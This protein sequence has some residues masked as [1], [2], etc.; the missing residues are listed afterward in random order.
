MLR[1]LLPLALVFTLLSPIAVKAEDELYL[2]GDSIGIEVRYDGV[3]VSGTYSIQT[4]EGT[5]DPKDNGIEIGDRIVAVNNQKVSS[6]NDLYKALS[7]YQQSK[8]Q[9]SLTVIRNQKTLQLDLNTYYNKSSKNFQSGLYI[10]D[11]ITGVGTLTFYDPVHK[12]FGALGHE[13]MDSDLKQIADV[14]LGTIYPATVNSITKAQEHIAGEKQATI[15]YDKPFANVV[16]NTPIGIYGTYDTLS[17]PNAKKLEWA[18]QEDIHIGKATIYTVLN[19]QEIKAYQIEITK[20]HKQK[21][22]DMKGIE[23]TITDEALLKETNGVIQGMSGSPIVQDG[24]I[25]GAITHV[26]TSNPHKGYGVYIEWMLKQA[27]QK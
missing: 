11:K 12:T 2:G 1:K 21:Q 26:I 20:L 7:S 5:Y 6:M 9:L 10:K 23:F 22:M 16:K 17:N 24:K 15:I 27:N 14:H 18:K 13:I 4:D 19:G 25:I 3:I 8:N